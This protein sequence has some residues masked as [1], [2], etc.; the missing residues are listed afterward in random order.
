L[1]ISLTCFVNELY[2]SLVIDNTGDRQNN[3]NIWN[4]HCLVY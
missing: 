2:F 3:V 1:A 4:T